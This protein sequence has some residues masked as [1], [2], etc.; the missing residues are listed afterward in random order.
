MKTVQATLVALT[1]V[2]N[3]LCPR[4]IKIVHHVGGGTSIASID[5]AGDYQLIYLPD[6]IFVRLDDNLETLLGFK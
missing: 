6:G 4:G 3:A 1:D 2:V 5:Q